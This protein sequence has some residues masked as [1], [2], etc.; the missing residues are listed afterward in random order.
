VFFRIFNVMRYRYERAVTFSP[1]TVRLYPRIDQAIITHRLKTEVSPAGDVQYRRDLFDNVIAQC[2]LGGAGDTLEISVRLEVEITPRNPFHFLVANHAIDLPFDYTESELQVLAPFCEIRPEDEAPTEDLWSFTGKRNTVEV[3]LSVLQILQREIAYEVRPEGD[4]RTPR[5]VLELRSG[6]CR[7]TAQ[8]CAVL[9]RKTGLAVRLVSGFFCEVD[10]E[11]KERRIDRELHAWVETYLPGAGWIGLDPTN[12]IFCDHRFIPTAVGARMTD[13]APIEGSYFGTEKVPAQ[14]EAHLDIQPRVETDLERLADR[15]EASLAEAELALTMGG[16]PTFVPDEPE[17]A[18][19]VYAAV[20][21]TKLGYAYDVAEAVAERVW[22][23]SVVFYTPGKLYP[24]EVNPRWAVNVIRMDEAC[25]VPI[26]PREDLVTGAATFRDL[27]PE[28]LGVAPAWQRAWD[29]RDEEHEVWV[30]PLDHVDGAWTSQAW[31]AK[32]LVLTLAEGPAGLRLPLNELP[33]GA[34][35][36][37]LV[38]DVFPDRLEIFLPPLL[39]EPFKAL[40]LKA[41]ALSPGRVRWQGYVPPDLPETWA[42]LGCTADP[43]VLELNLPPCRCWTEYRDWLVLLEKIT[44]EKGLRTIRKGR[45]PTGTGGG[46]H[47]LFGGPTLAANP[48]FT[49]PEWVA[50]ILRYWQHH[51]ALA[52]LFTGNYVGPAS[53][54]PRPDESGKTCLDLELACRQLEAL[55]AGDRRAEIHELLRHLQT[56]LGG[57]TH[58]SEASFD[59]FWN[60]PQGGHGLMEFRA[61]ETLPK[62]AW[63]GAVALLWRALLT[64]LYHRPF[65]ASLEDWGHRLHDQYLLPAFLWQDLTQILSDLAQ[66]GFGFDPDIFRAIWAWRFPELCVAGQVT[67]RRALDAWPPLAEVPMLGGSTSRFVDGSMERWE[68]LAAPSVLSAEAMFVNGRE[69]LFRKLNTREMITGIRFRAAALY[70]SLHPGIP[71]QVP[72]TLSMATRDENRIIQTWRYDGNEFVEM[73]EAKDQTLEPGPPCEAAIPGAYT[74]DL[75]I[76]KSFFG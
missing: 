12:G 39:V 43:G 2:I 9:L 56:D 25:E 62:P 76:E 7:D 20:G 24:G 40:V 4:A 19:W 75:R 54:A 14:F 63:S 8:L 60:L 18:E 51:P 55:S 23:G 11:I 34:P 49:R 38:L 42:V 52:Y 28:T 1:Q 50:S 21:P 36:R 58:R 22:P 27:L 53:Q 72:L 67:V 45:L 30:L 68:F 15:V 29:P 5:E 3:L 66:F 70:P 46:N 26:I 65:R 57:N 59:K 44:A 41:A 10:V 31:P 6:A 37:A 61:L 74:Y 16:E 71:V 47:L 69:L 64:Y 35:R 13:I 73:P 17:G 32:G 48:F 33:E